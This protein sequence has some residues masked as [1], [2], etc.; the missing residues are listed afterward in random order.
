MID[1]NDN[2]QQRVCKQY[3]SVQTS[4]LIKRIHLLFVIEFQMIPGLF[5][6]IVDRCWS[7]VF[8]F[9]WRASSNSKCCVV[10]YFVSLG[11]MSKIQILIPSFEITGNTLSVGSSVKH[12]RLYLRAHMI[13]F[14]AAFQLY[15]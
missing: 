15:A 12:L 8:L 2:L 11:V 3:H 9:M 1:N 4:V 13:S 6:V 10:V 14:A 7:A 5:H